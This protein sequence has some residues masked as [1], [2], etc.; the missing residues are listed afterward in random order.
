MHFQFFIAYES[1]SRRIFNLA[2]A[3][4]LGTSILTVQR[5]NAKICGTAIIHCAMNIIK[6]I[7]KKIITMIK[8]DLTK[9]TGKEDPVVTISI[10]FDDTNVPQCLQVYHAHKSI[11][12]GFFRI[13]SLM[14]SKKQQR[15]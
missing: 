12:G 8:E 9:A 14:S 11:V 1:M 13:T 5:I 6:D 4:L 7:A 3:N 10:G 15:N 2:S